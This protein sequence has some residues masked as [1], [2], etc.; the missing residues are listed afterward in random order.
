M[1]VRLTEIG[2]RMNIRLVKIEDGL[3]GG[4]GPVHLDT[5]QPDV[6]A[7]YQSTHIYMCKHHLFLSIYIILQAEPKAE[8]IKT[9]FSLVQ[10]L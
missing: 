5:I 8:R 2:P 9:V 1:K 6:Y 3:C 10:C 7:H 4:Q